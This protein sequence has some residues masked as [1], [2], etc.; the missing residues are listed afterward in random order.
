LRQALAKLSPNFREKITQQFLQNETYTPNKK[1]LQCKVRHVYM[2]FRQNFSQNK[3]SFANAEKNFSRDCSLHTQSLTQRKPLHGPFAQL[4]S[5]SVFQLFKTDILLVPVFSALAPGPA[6]FTV[7]NTWSESKE[8][9]G[10]RVIKWCSNYFPVYVS[11][12]L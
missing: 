8:V 10:H 12:F 4:S 1:Y 7:T 3:I 6:E 9:L 11:V 2:N 5:V